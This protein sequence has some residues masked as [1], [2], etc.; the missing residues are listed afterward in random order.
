M[1]RIIWVKLLY[2]TTIIVF[3]YLEVLTIYYSRILYKY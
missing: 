2:L 3:K 1:Q